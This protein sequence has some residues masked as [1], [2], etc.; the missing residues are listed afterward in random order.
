MGCLGEVF[1]R[2]AVEAT[3]HGLSTLCLANVP[4]S[5]FQRGYGGT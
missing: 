4:G 3:Q 5:D 1:E 2:R